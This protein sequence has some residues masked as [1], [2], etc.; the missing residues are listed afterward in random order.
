VAG[1]QRDHPADF[2]YEMMLALPCACKPLLCTL[3]ALVR[4]CVGHRIADL[5]GGRYGSMAHTALAVTPVVV[6]CMHCNPGLVA[7]VADSKLM[8]TDSHSNMPGQSSLTSSLSE[9]AVVR[10]SCCCFGSALVAVARTCFL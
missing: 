5:P 8:L 4:V 2:A 10:L 7:C 9:S 6:N 1:T 3:D